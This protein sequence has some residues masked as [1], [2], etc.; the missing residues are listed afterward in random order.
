ML[1]EKNT[2]HFQKIQKNRFSFQQ[3]SS[4]FTHDEFIS[5]NGK[6]KGP[7]R[8]MQRKSVLNSM[9]KGN[10]DAAAEA[11]IFKVVEIYRRYFGM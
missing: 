9:A 4:M 6:A 2:Q 3:N 1:N 5:V 8:L 7:H 11:A 10:C